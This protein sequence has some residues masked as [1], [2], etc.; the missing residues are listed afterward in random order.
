MMA[1]SIAYVSGVLTFSTLFLIG[2]CMSTTMFFGHITEVI[3]CG[4]STV[5]DEDGSSKQVWA[6]P[7]WERLVPHFMGYVPCIG[8]WFV[9]L[10]R[11]YGGFHGPQ[12]SA[13]VGT[14]MNNATDSDDPQLVEPPNFVF[15]IAYTQLLIFMSFAYVQLSVAI[16]GPM[17]YVRGEYAYC[18]LSAVSKTLLG[19]ILLANVLFLE[20]YECIIPEFADAFPDRC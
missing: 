1:C 17:A 14:G 6:L 12:L 20:D 10:L 16:K 19:S 15:A 5:Q 9:I 18:V 3:G 13:A 2:V 4:I 8:A 7:L 11:L